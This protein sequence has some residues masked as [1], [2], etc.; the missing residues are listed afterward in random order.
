MKLKKN[1]SELIDKREIGVWKEIKRSLLTGTLIIGPVMVTAYLLWKSFIFIDGILSTVVNKSLFYIFDL[2]FLSEYSI[3]GLGFITLILILGITGFLTRH[4]FG[5]NLVKKMQGFMNKIPLVNRVYKAIQQ[6]SDA[7]LSGR[8]EVFKSAVL[9]EYPRPGLHSI[10][11]TTTSNGGVVQE[12]LNKDLISVFVP[13]TPNPTS[14]FLLFVPR[15]EVTP[16]NISV[17]DA[18]KLIISGGTVSSPEELE[19][20]PSK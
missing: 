2:E 19:S 4:V 17:E 14:G 13:T 18:L 12:S 20:N 3:P 1:I 16:L 8:Q 5:Q 11:I 10:A 9:I 15:D 6:I 7:V